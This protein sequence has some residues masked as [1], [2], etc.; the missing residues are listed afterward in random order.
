MESE[1]WRSV[2]GF[3][4][5][6]EISNFGNVRS[7]DRVVEYFDPRW[8]RMTTKVIHG[9]LLKIAGDSYQFVQLRKDGCYHA[10]YIHRLVAESFIP[11]PENKPEVNHK[12]RNPKNNNI[13]NLEWVTPSENV[14]HAIQHGYDIGAAN[15]GNKLSEE[16][17]A[18]ISKALKG[19]NAYVHTV[20]TRNKFQRS[21]DKCRPVRC[22]EDNKSFLCIAEASRN[23]NVSPGAISDGIRVG[24]KVKKKWTFEY[25]TKGEYYDMAI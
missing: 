9:K 23:Y 4:Q 2:K 10:R 3:E 5:L 21:Y 25:I 20:D 16:H 11:N 14:R 24:R 6:Y 7:L 13:N 17:K 19:H 15:R 8:N 22:I 18:K 1:V 12:D